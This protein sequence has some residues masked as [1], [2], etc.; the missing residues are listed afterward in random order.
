MSFKER[1][2]ELRT[3]EELHSVMRE[4][5]EHGSPNWTLET[6]RKYVPL[7]LWDELDEY[8]D[9]DGRLRVRMD[10]ESGAATVTRHFDVN[11]IEAETRDSELDTFIPYITEN[12]PQTRNAI[13]QLVRRLHER[14]AEIASRAATVSPKIGSPTSAYEEA[15]HAQHGEIGSQTTV[16]PSDVDI[17]SD[18]DSDQRS[19]VET[20]FSLQ[21]A[22]DPTEVVC[23][24]CNG[25][26]ES[27]NASFRGMAMCSGCAQ[28][29]K[30]AFPI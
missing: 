24:I 28:A 30:R 20:I 11:E 5:V 12:L 23:P 4:L 8:F 18:A 15:R 17:D 9:S 13:S 7:T 29:L 3:P 16:G 21:P 22:D 19:H 25:N 6:A 1:M 2:T 26:F 14:L 27:L 10:D